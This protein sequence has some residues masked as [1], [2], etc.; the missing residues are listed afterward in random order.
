M[1]W[2]AKQR[3]ER[4]LGAAVLAAV[5][6]SPTAPGVARRAADIALASDGTVVVFTAVPV[7]PQMHTRFDVG[8]TDE[9]RVV[10][11]DGAA[12]VAR[13]LPI[14]DSLKVPYR[15][16][17]VPATVRWG[18]GVPPRDI[19]R[20]IRRAARDAGADVIVVGSRNPPRTSPIPMLSTTSSMRSSRS[21]SRREVGW[22]S[23]PTARL[24]ITVGSR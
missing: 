23:S 14:L 5:D 17:P 21:C 9:H 8:R 13:V 16:A 22:R 2:F 19:A 12:T 15:I 6:D 7:L 10:G 3:A 1:N 20:S 11:D 24:A 4:N 18:R